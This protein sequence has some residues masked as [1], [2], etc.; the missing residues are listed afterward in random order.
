MI[1]I[2]QEYKE[3]YED[4]ER[5]LAALREELAISKDQ[6][7]CTEQVKSSITQRLADAERRNAELDA[8]LS[9][10]TD[11]VGRLCASAGNQPS[12]ATGYLRDILDTL[13]PT[14]AAEFLAA[15]PAQEMSAYDALMSD[16]WM[17]PERISAET[18][19][20]TLSTDPNKSRR[21]SPEN[22]SDVMETL[23]QL[24]A[25]NPNPEAASHDE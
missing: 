12:V 10:A 1:S 3:R 5:K 9:K 19:Y 11:F 14:T 15:H 23:S 6:L 2:G 4:A 25:I 8:R 18:V 21:T 7:A 13:K 17:P 24:A 20:A 22:V 16:E